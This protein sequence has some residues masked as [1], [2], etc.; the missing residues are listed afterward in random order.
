MSDFPE[1]DKR[2]TEGYTPAVQDIITQLENIR[3]KALS[4]IELLKK[5]DGVPVDQSKDQRASLREVSAEILNNA[6]ILPSSV[7]GLN[8]VLNGGTYRS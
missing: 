1:R 6:T 3:L 8:R 5:I 4:G 7:K 2:L